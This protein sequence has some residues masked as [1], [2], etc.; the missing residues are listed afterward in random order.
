MLLLMDAGRM[1]QLCREHLKPNSSSLLFV[2]LPLPCVTNSRYMTATGF[3]EL[4]TAV[5]FRLV[6]QQWKE[7]GKVAYWLFQWAPTGPQEALQ[8]WSSKRLVNDGPGRNNFSIVVPQE[9]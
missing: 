9:S 6:K 1:L 3:S 7:G 8:R 5:G 2:V 4:V